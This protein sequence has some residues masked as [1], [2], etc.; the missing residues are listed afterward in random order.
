MGLWDGVLLHT[1]LKHCTCSVRTQRETLWIEEGKELALLGEKVALGDMWKHGV[2]RNRRWHSDS[3]CVPTESGCRELLI[4]F[5]FATLTA[6]DPPGMD[7]GE[8]PGL[9]IGKSWH[10]ELV[11]ARESESQLGWKRPLEVINPTFD[12]TP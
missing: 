9:V 5:P 6:L 12:P 4:P 2:S 3:K 10:I 11:A 7:R 1:G 8:T